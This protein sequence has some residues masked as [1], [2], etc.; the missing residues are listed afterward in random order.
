MADA[1]QSGKGTGGGLPDSFWDSPMQPSG[2][3]KVCPGCQTTLPAG[4]VLCTHCGMNLET[5]KAIKTRVSVEK[6]PKSNDGKK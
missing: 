5:G 2:G 1:V 3:A 4:S 6:K